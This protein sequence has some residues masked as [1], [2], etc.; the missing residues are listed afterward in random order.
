M[1]QL[2][3]AITSFD[4]WSQPWTFHDFILKK[5]KIAENEKESFISM[6]ALA[7][8]STNWQ[9]KNFE[10]CFKLIHD[11]LKELYGLNDAAISN[12]IRAASYEWR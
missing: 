1:K 8:E 4:N 7:N 11:K 10:L 9:E 6:W 2:E 12:V 3:I 5:E